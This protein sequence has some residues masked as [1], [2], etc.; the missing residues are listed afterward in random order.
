MITH[1]EFEGA[2]VRAAEVLRKTGIA[3]RPEELELMEVADFGLGELTVTG[4]QI[5]TLV[6]TDK[7]AAK[8]LVQFPGQTEPEHTHPRLGRYEGKEETIR[9]QWGELRLYVPGSPTA[10]PRGCPPAHRR[11]T[12]T[13]WHEILLQSGEQVTL[14]PSTPH[15]FQA[16]PEG[17]VV[18]SFSTKVL[19]AQD[20][21][22]DPAIRRET[23]VT[24]EGSGGAKENRV[25]EGL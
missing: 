20:I 15:W 10:N 22:T 21:F 23:I 5:L 3:L 1:K 2:R 6:N 14:E 18:W 24:D 4:V 25:T 19:D 9:C 13:V 17:A 16:G 7:I 11:E 8:L 12:Y